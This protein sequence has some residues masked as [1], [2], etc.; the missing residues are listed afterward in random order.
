MYIYTELKHRA[1][2]ILF[3]FS[4]GKLFFVLQDTPPGSFHG[5]IRVYPKEF[6]SILQFPSR[7][8]MI[9]H[10]TAFTKDF[11]WYSEGSTGILCNKY[12][13]CISSDIASPLL[14]TV[15]DINLLAFEGKKA[16][17]KDY[18]GSFPPFPGKEVY[19]PDLICR[20]FAKFSIY[21]QSYYWFDN[22]INVFNATGLHSS[23]NIW[24]LFSFT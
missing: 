13:S 22:I 10:I 2:S 6:N 14:Y 24:Q 18:D 8:T 12:S 19:I 9:L 23:K 11:M 4:L 20:V 16:R 15:Y 3:Y 17:K 21:F 1:F 7:Y 5:L